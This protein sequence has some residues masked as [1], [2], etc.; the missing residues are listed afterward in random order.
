MVVSDV[1][2]LD[3]PPLRGNPFDLRPIERAR[4]E[5]IVARDEILTV[6]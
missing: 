4:A 5:D 1:S 2:M 6:Y 3:V